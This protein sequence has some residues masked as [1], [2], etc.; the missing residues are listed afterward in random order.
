VPET[1]AAWRKQNL[2]YRLFAA[3]DRFVRDKLA[4]VN[5]GGFAGITDALLS[6]LINIDG[7]GTRVTDIAARAGLTKQS[8][9]ELIDRAEKLGVVRREADPDDK[10]ARIVC[11]TPLGT[12]LCHCLQQAIIGAEQRFANITGAE[13]AAQFKHRFGAYSAVPV[14]DGGVVGE[15]SSGRAEPSWRRGNV[16][17]VLALA[18]RRFARDALSHVHQ[19][20]YREV[21]EVTLALFRNLDREGTRLTE[22]AAR[23]HM[24]KQSMR[25]LVNRAEILGFV[26]RLGDPADR[27]AKII[28]FTPA[29]LAMLAQMRIGLAEAEAAAGAIVGEAFLAETRLRLIDYTVKLRQPENPA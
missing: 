23:A 5:E 16:G 1:N 21:S 29:G 20:N 27:R 24:T 26:E 11:F 28:A 14:G 19:H 8:V 12:R 13:F 2:G 22:I 25:E 18:S 4:S 10:R 17:R 15:T 6:L 7:V 9:V 3:N